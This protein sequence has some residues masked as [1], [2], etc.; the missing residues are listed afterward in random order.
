MLGK[1]LVLTMVCAFLSAHAL[2]AERKDAPYHVDVWSSV[3]FGKDGKAGEYRMI[4][5]AEL[6]PAFAKEVRNRLQRARIEP[7]LVGG[8]PV[9][10]R[11]GVRMI[12]EVS[13]TENGG[14]V[15][16]TGLQMAPLP[17]T[18]FLASF[19]TDIAAAAG[20]Q[21]TVTAT[22]FVSKEGRCASTEVQALP[23]VPESARRWA[24]ESF[25]RWVFEPL[26]LDG[27]PVEGEFPMTVS[28]ETQSPAFEDF[29]QDKFERLMRRN[30]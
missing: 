20:W 5:E 28:L 21:G 16:L 24:A 25:K 14:T 22:C 4:D 18:R 26:L 11:T 7:R 6:S 10:Y 15:R 3:L 9:T 13:P 12:F 2:A 17:I 29:R 30:F 1:P 8:N 19:P 27:A 23:G